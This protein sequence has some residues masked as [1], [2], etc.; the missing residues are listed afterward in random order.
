MASTMTEPTDKLIPEPPEVS[1]EA[2]LTS[3]TTLTPPKKLTLLPL[4][5]VVPHLPIVMQ[6]KVA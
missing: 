6:R 1:S 4:L 5:L 3:G 2:T